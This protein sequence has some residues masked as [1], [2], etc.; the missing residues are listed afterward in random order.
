ME[1]NSCDEN[2]RKVQQFSFKCLKKVDEICQKYHITYYLDSGTLIGAIRHHSFIPWDDDID[3]AFRREEY[4]KL[5]K[6]P[7]EEW[8]EDFELVTYRK[9]TNEAAFL[10]L[11]TRVIYTKETL[12]INTY[13]KAAQSCLEKYRNCAALDCFILD[14]A[15]DSNFLQKILV[16]KLN[17]IYGLL[18]GHRDYINFNEYVGVSRFAVKFLSTLGK[19]FSLK[20]LFDLYEKISQS[21][22]S[23]SKRFYYSN[24]TIKEVRIVY[25]KDWYHETIKVPFGSESFDAPAGYHQI[26]STSYGDYMTPPSE[27]E[28]KPKH[29]DS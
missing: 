11:T 16:L 29:M 26:L 27:E 25:D 18:M 5:L 21:T 20:K 8:G 10:D 28:R 2:L 1:N 24:Y 19:I 13:D 4:N 15:Y 17:V 14:D 3:I 22:P 23:T 7:A 12:P 9:L 6:V